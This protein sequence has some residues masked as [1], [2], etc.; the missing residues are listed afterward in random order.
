MILECNHIC[1]REN[2][3]YQ[4]NKILAEAYNVK[5]TDIKN[6]KVKQKNEN[7]AARREKTRQANESLATKKSRVIPLRK[8]QSESND[9]KFSLR[10]QPIKTL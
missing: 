8:E 7:E 9:G 3:I 6:A 1:Y 10:F 4:I 5:I 2:T